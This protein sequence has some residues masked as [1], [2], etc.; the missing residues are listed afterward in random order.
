VNPV[1]KKEEPKKKQGFFAGVG[2]FFRRLFG[3]E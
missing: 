1:P 3:A 2:K